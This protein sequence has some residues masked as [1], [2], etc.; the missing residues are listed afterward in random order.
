MWPRI[1][2]VPQSAWTELL[3]TKPTSETIQPAQ[4]PS[5]ASQV[6]CCGLPAHSHCSRCQR[7]APPNISLAVPTADLAGQS[8]PSQ[9]AQHSWTQLLHFQHCSAEWPD[10]ENSNFLQLPFQPTRLEQQR[11]A[12]HQTFPV[13]FTGMLNSPHQPSAPNSSPSAWQLLP[14][15]DYTAVPRDST[16]TAFF[17]NRD[18]LV[19][20]LQPAITAS[21]L[22]SAL[23]LSLQNSAWKNWDGTL[24]TPKRE[25]TGWDCAPG[26]WTRLPAGA[27]LWGWR[28]CMA[29]S[30]LLVPTQ[31]SVDAQ[32]SC[33]HP[34]PALSTPNAAPV[35]GSRAA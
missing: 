7:E 2:Q 15:Q 9:A 27:L 5:A 33:H 6:P 31:V 22:M 26:L 20:A 8:V 4:I 23:L 24:A 35:Q 32:G 13:P 10:T 30:E 29:S 19:L 21:L 12:Q 3:A 34:C 11:K 28:F 1:K 16:H 18:F 25:S 14:A 17:S